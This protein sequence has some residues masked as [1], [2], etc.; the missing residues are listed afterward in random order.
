MTQCRTGR[1]TVHSKRIGG[2]S[3]TLMANGTEKVVL[4]LSLKGVLLLSEATFVSAK[5]TSAFAQIGKTLQILCVGNVLLETGV[6][7]TGT[8]FAGATRPLPID[9]PVD[10]GD[11]VVWLNAQLVRMAAF[12]RVHHI[13][14]S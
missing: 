4:K 7:E 9:V 2:L 8:S 14:T 1:R 6:E 13:S 3:C 12:N 5:F 10:V 11:L